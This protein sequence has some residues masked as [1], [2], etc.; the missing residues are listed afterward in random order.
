LLG[1]QEGLDW[2]DERPSLAGLLVLENGKIVKSKKLRN[3]LWST[4]YGY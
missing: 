4:K 2:L 1:S 3:H